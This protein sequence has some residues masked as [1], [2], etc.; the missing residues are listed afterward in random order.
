MTI[1]AF[2]GPST[3]WGGHDNGPFHVTV[4]PA[5]TGDWER[6]KITLKFVAPHG[7]GHSSFVVL[8]DPE[9]FAKVAQA[10]M[11][12]APGSAVK[13]FGAAMVE[14]CRARSVMELYGPLLE[15]GDKP[16]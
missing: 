9:D 12:V 15:D 13:A 1:R 7:K 3:Q 5:T 14:G 4:D 2:R 11:D 6:D 10:M 16:E 8:I